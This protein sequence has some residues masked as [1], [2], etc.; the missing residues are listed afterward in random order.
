MQAVPSTSLLSSDTDI[1]LKC[2][3]WHPDSGIGLLGRGVDMASV[4]TGLSS[5]RKKEER[6]REETE[7]SK[8]LNQYL[9]QKYGAGSN[10]A[11]E[12]P[13][14]KKKKK[15]AASASAVRVVD[16]DVTGYH[17]LTGEG[18]APGPMRPTYD[19]DEPAE[20]AIDE[21]GELGG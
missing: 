21:E 4:F 8:A 6:P 9:A 15:A 16:L 5:L 11:A 18:A 1:P 12:K 2:T 19:S 10:G 13:R 14:K 7:A 17:D 20:E 3:Q